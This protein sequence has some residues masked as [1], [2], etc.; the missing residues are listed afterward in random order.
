M[1]IRVCVSQIGISYKQ[2]TTVF[3]ALAVTVGGGLLE[4]YVGMCRPQGYT[5]SAKVILLG[6]F[7]PGK[8]ILIVTFGQRKVNFGYSG[9]ETQNFKDFGLEKV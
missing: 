4:R 9:K 1:K 7:S 2:D 8:G 6:N 3:N 5:F